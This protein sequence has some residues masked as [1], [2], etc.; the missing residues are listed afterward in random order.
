MVASFRFESF[1]VRAFAGLTALAIAFQYGHFLEHIVQVL[2]WMT[3]YTHAPYMTDMGYALAHYLG[4]TFF[5]VDA[6]ERIHRLGMELLH[7]FGNAI[8][9]VG[10]LGLWFF[11]R[12]R[13]V[14]AAVIIQAFHLVE[15]IS[16]TASSMMF[17]QAL[18][19]STLYG[20]PLSEFTSVAYRVWLHFIFNA[21]PTTLVSY[22]LVMRL[23]QHIQ[24]PRIPFSTASAK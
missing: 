21:I 18:G 9:L 7:L 13:L 20:M 24:W 4:Q 23:R 2:A 8:F 6:P 11:M 16:L 1:A 3:G 19:L 22:A 12:T 17:D 5:P 14:K 10:I 15:H